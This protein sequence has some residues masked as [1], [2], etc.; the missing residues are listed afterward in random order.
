MSPI[1]ICFSR[2][3]RFQFCMVQVKQRSAEFSGQVINVLELSV[4]PGGGN[5]NKPF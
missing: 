5:L 3:I 4:N 1:I 2:K